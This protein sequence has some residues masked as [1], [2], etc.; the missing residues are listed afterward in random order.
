MKKFIL[1][2]ICIFQ[3][4]YVFADPNNDLL[5]AVK[6]QDIQEV[7]KALLNGAN[8]NVCYDN[9]FKS[10]VLF[11]SL[12]NCDFEIAKLLISKGADV[13][14]VRKNEYS[15]LMDVLYDGYEKKDSCIEESVS[16]LL[17]NGVNVNYG[18]DKDQN[19]LTLAVVS[20]NLKIVKML[21]D[22]GLVMSPV[23][24]K[25]AQVMQ[26]AVLGGNCDVVKFILEKGFDINAKDDSGY[27]PLMTVCGVDQGM[28]TF[29]LKN[30]KIYIDVVK[31]LLEKKALINLRNNK[32][33]TALQMAK[34]NGYI[35]IVDL[36]KKAGAK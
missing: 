23:N 6:N 34:K 25:K 15:I 28:A 30:T 17:K 36:L 11:H 27:T 32:G 21:Y 14:V 35:E 5:E 19:A 3:S 16:Y 8:A 29:F 9:Y 10:S 26:Y 31:L 13:N 24:K 20:G 4:I 12:A 33:Q 22:N 18:N 7:K 2:I 1:V